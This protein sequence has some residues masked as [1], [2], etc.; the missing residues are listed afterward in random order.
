MRNGIRWPEASS[1]PR[2]PRRRSTLGPGKTTV[3]EPQPTPRSL[4]EEQQELT[5]SRIREAAMKVVARRGFGATVAEIAEL[6]GVSART[7]FRH[8]TSHDRLILATVKDMYEAWGRTPIEGLPRL[9][10]DPDGWL[11]GLALTVHTRSAEIIGEAFWDMHAPG[12]LAPDVF[13]E[14]TALRHEYRVRGVRFLCGLA[15]TMVGGQGEPPEALTLT[16]ALHLSGFATH[17]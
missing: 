6:S 13:S 4:A 15:W 3:N 8:Y 16:F 11:E 12:H 5:R 1:T 10:D 7:I 17:A 14:I 2:T 9:E